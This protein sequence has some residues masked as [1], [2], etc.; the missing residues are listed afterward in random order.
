[1]SENQLVED[2]KTDI[3]SS[4]NQSQ[5][6]ETS[7]KLKGILSKWFALPNL[8][9]L[10]IARLGSF[11]QKFSDLTV[12]QWL[13]LV[14]GVLLFISVDQDVEGDSSLIWVGAIAGIGLM[15]ELWHVF[16]RLWDNILGK[17]LVLVLYAATAN[18]AVAIAALKVNAITGIEPGPFVFTIGFTTLLMLPFW[19]LMSSIVFFS[20]TLIVSN[21]WL[22]LSILL[23]VIRIKVKIHWED[24]SF[25]FA[26]ML[27]R[28]ILIPYVIM[29]IFHLA[30]PFAEQIEIFDNPISHVRNA[31]KEQE[32]QQDLIDSLPSDNAETPSVNVT[33]DP[34]LARIISSEDRMGK[35]VF[36]QVIANF[37]YYFETYPSSKCKKT[38]EQ[39]S[40]PIDENLLLLVEKNDSELGY[41]FFVGPCEGNYTNPV[42]Q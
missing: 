12:S 15:R 13:Y 2:R 19:L 9:R 37:I 25:V 28:V 39:R 29:S 4:D 35:G 22:I 20:I 7:E 30:V 27:L 6:I 21:L 42:T 16:N 34:D 3:Q 38:T 33:V 41:H 36:D 10:W 14:A 18:F 24:R 40:L 26:T 8:R 1:M 23:R 5:P 17:G 32:K 31:I 11:K